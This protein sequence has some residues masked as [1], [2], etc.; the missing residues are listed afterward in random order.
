M[1]KNYIKPLIVLSAWLI[2]VSAFAQPALPP[3]GVPAGA[4]PAGS[5]PAGAPP[6]GGGLG[7]MNLDTS[8]YTRKFQNIP[9]A[10][11]SA[12][13]KLDI[14]LPE[15]G[16]RLPASVRPSERPARPMEELSSRQRKI[17]LSCSY[18]STDS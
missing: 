9:Y 7:G 14:Y 8:K 10:S 5:L 6:M 13:Q 12:T 16:S 15:T 18:F 4:P 2:A 1:N 11:L 17:S 3:G